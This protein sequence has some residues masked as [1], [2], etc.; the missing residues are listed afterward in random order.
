MVYARVVCSADGCLS[1]V[2]M[3]GHVSPAGGP[4]GGNIV[5]AAITGLVRSC[6]EV[7]VRR[8]GIS[9]DGTADAEGE[10]MLSVRQVGAEQRQW[11]RGVSDVLTGG[12]RRIAAESPDELE[13]EVVTLGPGSKEWKR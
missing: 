10:F 9:A 7:I 5:C 2:T 6:A 11:L 12:L 8:D 13:L 4:R 3:R 1:Q